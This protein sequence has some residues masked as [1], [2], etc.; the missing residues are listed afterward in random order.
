VSATHDFRGR[1]L[2]L[3]LVFREKRTAREAARE[4]GT[5]TGSVYGL[6]K[7]MHAEGM[8]EA[9]SDP[10][11]PTRGTQYCLTDDARFALAQALESTQVEREDAGRLTEGQHVL[12]ASGAGVMAVQRVVADPALSAAVA[13]DA[14]LGASWLFAMNPESSF[15][16]L[17][18][19]A[20][21][22]ERA[23]CDCQLGQVDG[24]E[25]G[26]QMREQA[27]L[28]VERAGALR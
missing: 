20:A 2:D 6:I 5:Q 9:D 1:R 18:K 13:W 16:T 8:L 24:L 22:L 23:G 7:R 15:L 27:S 14:W 17:K 25:A 21:A 3:A 19:L 12:I 4:L 10:A 26:G 28:E 11:P